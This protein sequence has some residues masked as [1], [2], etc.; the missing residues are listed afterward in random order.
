MPMQV[1]MHVGM[2][3]HRRRGR[4]PSRR[5]VACQLTPLTATTTTQRALTVFALFSFLAACDM[6]AA[7]PSYLTGAILVAYALCE[8]TLLLQIPLDSALYLGRQVNETHAHACT[9]ARRSRS[10][11]RSTSGGR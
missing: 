8:L 5:Q 2:C 3:M 6:H 11:R 9:R 4:A 1:R 10:T 7:A